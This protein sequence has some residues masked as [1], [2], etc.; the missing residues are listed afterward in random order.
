MSET[1]LISVIHMRCYSEKG[2]SKNAD[3]GKA[4]LCNNRRRKRHGIRYG[5][6][7]ID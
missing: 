6:R 2:L 5:D 1:S 3:I 4:S 7:E